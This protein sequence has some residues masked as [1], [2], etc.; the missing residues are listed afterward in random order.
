MLRRHHFQL[1]C[2]SSTLVWFNAFQVKLVGRL[3]RQL[4]LVA[5]GQLQTIF[6]R[7]LFAEIEATIKFATCRQLC[8][9]SHGFGVID[10][11]FEPGFIDRVIVDDFAGNRDHDVRGNGGADAAQKDIDLRLVIRLGGDENPVRLLSHHSVGIEQ[12]DFERQVGFEAGDLVG[13]LIARVGRRVHHDLGPLL[14]GHIHDDSFFQFLVGSGADCNL[15]AD[16]QFGGR[17]QIQRARQPERQFLV[18]HVRWKLAVEQRF[19]HGRVIDHVNRESS[20]VMVVALHAERG[21]RQNPLQGL[22]VERIKLVLVAGAANLFHRHSAAI[23]VR[24]AVID[25]AVVR[26]ASRRHVGL[27]AQCQA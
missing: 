25:R 22:F 26:H 12:G 11:N 27:H 23:A 1:V 10:A 6:R 16:G 20:Q 18:H 4:H 5:N 21:G 7:T 9:E 17:G 24:G 19:D 3:D 15:R 2:V 13:K 14:R 8:G